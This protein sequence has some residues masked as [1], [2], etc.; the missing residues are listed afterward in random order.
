M[1]FKLFLLMLLSHSSFAQQISFNESHQHIYRLPF[2]SGKTVLIMQGYNGKY[3]HKNKFAL[4]FR[5][6][7]GK[8]VCAAR[9]GKVIKMVEHNN[10]GGGNI[11]FVSKANYVVIDHGDGTYAGYWHLEQNGALVEVGDLV[12]VGDKIGKSGSTGF[13]TMAHLHFMVYSYDKNGKQH[14]V[15]T[16]FKTN[17]KPAKRLR[18]YSLVKSPRDS[19]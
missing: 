13:S 8:S 18:S 14:T 19:K 6:R 7:K 12:K 2:E 16:F 4:D 5:L 1:R 9:S 15:P 11:K 10:E 17:R 3:S